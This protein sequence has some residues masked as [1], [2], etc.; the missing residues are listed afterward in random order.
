MGIA[1]GIG[2]LNLDP[3]NIGRKT[4]CPFCTRGG[5]VDDITTDRGVVIRHTAD[6]WHVVSVAVANGLHWPAF[7]SPPFDTTKLR[8]RV[9]EEVARK[10]ARRGR[11]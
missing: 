9:A 2:K 4:S 1:D 5:I 10:E 8:K 3:V 11:D 6:L 7:F